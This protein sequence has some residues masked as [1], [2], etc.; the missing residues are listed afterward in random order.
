ME[1]SES[2]DGDGGGVAPKVEVAVLRSVLYPV[3]DMV[4][5]VKFYCDALGLRLVGRDGDRFAALD[6]GVATLGLVGMEERV[7]GDS[8]SACFRVEDLVACIA[9]AENAGATV[10]LPLA[11]G[12]HEVRATMRDPSGNAF[13][14]YSRGSRR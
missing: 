10:V 5:A 12:A 8:A 3:R 14:L 6:G 9:R 13:V 1:S 7:S 2:R 4:A 11:E